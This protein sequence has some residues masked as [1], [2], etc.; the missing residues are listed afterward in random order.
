MSNFES[1]HMIEALRSGVPSRS[2]GA[3]FSSSRPNFIDN[4][5]EKLDSVASSNGSSSFVFSGR[6]GEGKTH[7]LN[8]IFELSS[9]RNMVVTLLPLS[10]ETPM[11]NLQVLYKKVIEN[12]YLP[13]AGQPG[14]FRDIEN[15]ITLKSD[16]AND[17]LLFAKEEL[18]TDRLFYVFKN[19]LG[20]FDPDEHFLM[21]VDLE[22]DLCR[23]DQIKQI[24]TK[25]FKKKMQ[26]ST[27]FKRSEHMMD[28]FCFMSHLFSVVGYSGWVILFDEAE[29]IG[30]M[31]RKTRMKAYANM[32]EF[33]FPQSH[34]ENVL[35]VFAFSSSFIEEVL[36][37]R[38]DIDYAMELPEDDMRKTSICKTIDTILNCEELTPFTQDDLIAS[39]KSIMEIYQEAYSWKAPC[40]EYDV[41]ERV[42]KAG[43]LL[44]TKIRASIEVLDQLYLNGAFDDVEATA[45]TG[46]DLEE[47]AS[48]AKLFNID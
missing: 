33:L 16:K 1:R 18:E 40:T 24:H 32:H 2:I 9:K 42:K 37:E 12:T 46:D 45:V 36:R 34:F 35:S 21:Q 5:T 27:P 11:N 19:Y 48:L 39:I 44:R 38:N 6:Y 30:R 8:T 3:Y 47:D 23:T 31:G 25:A 10:K 22:G 26:F 7:M 14:V 13:K 41:L 29:L 43:Y 20:A 15:Q 4:I 17:A 28:Y